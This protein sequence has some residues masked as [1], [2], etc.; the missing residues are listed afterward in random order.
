MPLTVGTAG[1]IDHGK[2]WL[3]RA[4]TG[5]D[6]D[7]LPEERERGISIALGYAPLTLPDGTQ[8]SLVDVPGHERFV[9]TMVAGA[10]GIDL[11][12]LVI[13]AG[14]GA[15]PQ[16][17][18]HLAI[19]R[20]LGIERGVVAVTKAD[21]VD[22]ETLELARAEAGELVPGAEVVAV[23]AKNG[24]GLDELREALARAAAAV[25]SRPDGAPTRLYVDRAF[26]IA[27]AGT[28]VTGTLRSGSIAAGDELR[29]EPSGLRTR[30]RSVQVHDVQVG[31]ADAGQRVAV[32]L[33]GISVPQLRRGDVL[34][35]PGAYPV[36]WRL[37]LALEELEPVPAAVTVHIGTSDVAARVV[38]EGRFAQLRLQEPVVAARGD[39][40]VLRTETTVGG[41]VV[42]DPSPPRRFD[43]ARLKLLESGDPESIVRALVYEP[44]TGEAL[45]AR[46]LLAPADLARGLA[47]VGSAADWFFAPE[48]LEEQ[49]SAVR[50]RLV[51]RA[52]ASPLDPGIPLAELLP[53]EPWAPAVLQLLHVERR[54][55]K[56]YAPGAAPKLGDQAAAAAELEAKLASEDLVRVEDRNLAG[57]LEDRGSLKRVGD[58]FAVSTALYERGVETL[59]TLSPITLAAFRDAL[60]ISRRTAQLL[61]E[62]YDADGLTL[63]VGDERRLR[64]RPG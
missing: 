7:R 61:L 8:L 22:G 25:G 47:P 24:A 33:P 26:T 39:R 53:P 18:E 44:I 2:T 64:T 3:V 17:H 4:L 23:S 60:G 51:E 34:V 6:T 12:L 38:R 55:G 45:Q 14:E 29:V 5:K 54:D 40:V 28:V 58:G 36:S 35:E 9:R 48:W 50:A 13:D 21:A 62:R 41:G 19:L 15:R 59:Q 1:H 27:G 63:R 16:T 56:A 31:Q 37:D 43:A 46:G 49:R 57:F 52:Q 20:L 32:N 30:A 10:T 42:L 11:F